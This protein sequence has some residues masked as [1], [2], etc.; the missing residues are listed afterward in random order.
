MA[1]S[2][3]GSSG[4]SAGRAGAASAG[5]DGNTTAGTALASSCCFA[6]FATEAVASPFGVAFSLGCL[7]N[8]IAALYRAGYCEDEARS[9]KA[10]AAQGV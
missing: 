1:S 9:G 2:A 4:R 3:D 6:F 8:P 7:L 5:G 10:A